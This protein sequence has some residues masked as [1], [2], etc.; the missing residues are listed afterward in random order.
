MRPDIIVIISPDRQPTPGVSEA[1][2]D[3]LVE[4]FIAQ[5]T[6]ERL[7]ESVLGWL[8]G[9]DVMPVNAVSVLPVEDGARSKFCSIVADNGLRLA[10]EPDQLVEFASDARAGERCVSDQTEAF[11][12]AVVDHAEDAEAPPWLED[13]RQKVERPA[14]IGLCGRADRRPDAGRAFAAARRRFTDRPSS[15]YS[16]RSF[17]WFMR[18]PSRS[19]MRPMRR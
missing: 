3:G 15:A 1:C 11:A 10:I 6:I 13:I 16:L 8:A 14:F 18:V 19:S 17:L 2:E 9:R 4:E 5:A 12:G 7:D